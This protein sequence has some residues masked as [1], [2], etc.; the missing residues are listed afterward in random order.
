MNVVVER[1]AWTLVHSVW[2]LLSERDESSPHRTDEV[3]EFVLCL[4]RIADCRGD[5]INDDVAEAFPQAMH[6]DF[7]SPLRQLQRPGRFDRRVV[8]RWGDEPALQNLEAREFS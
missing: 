6:G 7:E 8:A 5:A 1:L 3:V 4:N 2:Q